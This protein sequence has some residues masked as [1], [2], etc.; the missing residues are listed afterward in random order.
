MIPPFS[1][2]VNILNI[3]IYKINTRHTSRLTNPK[4]DG[5]IYI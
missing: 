3:K 4:K 5:K 1:H 2:I